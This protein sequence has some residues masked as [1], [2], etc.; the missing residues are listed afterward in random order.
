MEME[1]FIIETDFVG[2]EH[3]YVITQAILVDDGEISFKEFLYRLSAKEIMVP[4]EYLKALFSGLRA[5]REMED[6]KKES[7]KDYF[8]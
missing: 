2:T 5:I 7:A 3:E 8:G 1:R 6:S 4:D